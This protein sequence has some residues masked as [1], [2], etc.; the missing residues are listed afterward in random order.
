M[1]DEI[2][3]GR[4][5][6]DL[7]GAEVTITREADKPTRLTFPA[8]SEAPVDRWFGTEVL[9][10][11]D[12]SI[13]MDR[14]NAGAAP[15]LFNHDWNDPV[16]M[17]DGARVKDGRLYVEAHFFD[18]ERA[19]EVAAMVD[20]G[21]RNVSIGYELYEVVEDTKTNRYTATDWGVLEVS[22]ATVPADP[23][24]GVG[25]SADAD[26]KPVRVTR[27]QPQATIPA[28]AAAT[29]RSAAMADPIITAAPTAD[30]VSKLDPLQVEKD[31]RTAIGNLCRANKIDSRIEDQWVRDG[32]R[33]EEVAGKILEVVEDRGRG[34][35]TAM[36]DLGLT[37]AE[38]TR[39]SLFRAI[40]AMRTPT[41]DNV[42]AAAYEMECSRALAKKLQRDDS[43]SIFIPGEVLQRPLGA[44][45]ATR[46]MATTPGSKGGYLVNV[47]NMGFI[48]IL[49]NRSVTMRMGARRLSGLTGNVVF[50]R[51]TGKVSVTWQGGEGTSVTAADQ[52]LGQ[53]SMTPKT[54]IAITDVSEQ[55]LRQATP[56]AEAFVMAD[57]AADIAIDGVDYTAINGTGGAQPLG[58]KNTTGI[59]SGQ[60][61]ATATYAKVLAFVSTAGGSNAIRG[62]PG[63]VT[64]TAGAAVLMQRQRFTSTDTPLW[65]G[66]MLDGQC[67]GFNA[68]SS[69]QLASGN[70]IFGSW[71]EVVIGEWG[72]LELAMDNGGTRFNQAQVGIRAMWMVDVLVRYPQA[73]VVSVNLS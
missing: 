54:A 71:D 38:T 4:L 32:V 16:G 45:A 5:A 39:F 65:T 52:A 70:L 9:R 17:V 27:E 60:D 12:K 53:L 19:R 22:F 55:L 7:F 46:A 26:T 56:S 35:P 47:E 6:R 68:M 24:V 57:L 72:V 67:V 48:D 15:L 33:L 51:Q 11:D 36:S 41:H 42:A 34:N 10:H 66:N 18:T 2:K 61:A 49:R 25:R 3:V 58:I 43:G 13:R 20:G 63:F 14:L 37:R 1:T 23:S 31:R 69:E 8:S 40:R 50:P 29:T 62:N 28:A 44:E 30:P 73:F 21:M 59:T 64:N